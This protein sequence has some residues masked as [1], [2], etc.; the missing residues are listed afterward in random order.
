MGSRNAGVAIM[1]VGARFSLTSIFVDHVLL[2]FD[3]LISS[4]RHI[5]K[6]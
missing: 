6:R 4:V 5:R 2:I 3:S 1:T